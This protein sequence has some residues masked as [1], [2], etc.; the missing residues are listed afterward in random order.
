[1]IG[2]RGRDAMN[3]VVRPAII[4]SIGLAS[5]AWAVCC[6][7]RAPTAPPSVV[8]PTVARVTVTGTIST[9][10]SSAQFT[11]TATMSDNTTQDVTTQ[12]TWR[13]SDSTVVTVSATGVVSALAAGDA[14]VTAT[15]SNVTGVMHV[16]PLDV[17]GRQIAVPCAYGIA[18][19]SI[20]DV[21]PA[22]GQ[23]A[24][25]VTRSAGACPW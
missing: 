3:Y 18:P 25:E 11:A 12:A 7:G 16:R 22:G 5:L 8:T 13:S 4:R 6:S 19:S 23:Y 17:G 14:D 15:Y 24:T 2:A 10:A 1:M 9:V 21:P 20:G